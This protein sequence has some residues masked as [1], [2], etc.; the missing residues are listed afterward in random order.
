MRYTD[1]QL[2]EIDRL[3]A[4]HVMGWELHSS[5]F[6]TWKRPDGSGVESDYWKPTRSGDSML[7][8]EERVSLLANYAGKIVVHRDENGVRGVCLKEKYVCAL[9]QIVGIRDVEITCMGENNWI[10]HRFRSDE[11]WALIH[12]T[13]VQRCLAALAAVGKPW[14]PTEKSA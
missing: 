8:V 5:D 13:P 12:A 10:G 9:M 6:Y 2:D 3:V 14:K 4:G 1:E 7:E 11:L